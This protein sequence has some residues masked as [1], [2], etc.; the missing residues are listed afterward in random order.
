MGPEGIWK[1][2]WTILLFFFES[3]IS[4]KNSLK[5]ITNPLHLNSPAIHPDPYIYGVLDSSHRNRVPHF[6]L[7]LEGF[8]LLLCGNF[9]A[10][11][12]SFPG[13]YS[14]YLVLDWV[15]TYAYFYLSIQTCPIYLSCADC[16]VASENVCN[17]QRQC[18]N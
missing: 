11:F 10:F 8:F 2:L 16:P 5:T 9:Q 4:L 13:V 15:K 6:T 1:H 3:K 12:I 7:S 18:L 17:S 14:M